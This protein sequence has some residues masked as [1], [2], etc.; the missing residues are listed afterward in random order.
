M[1]CALAVMLFSY[2]RDFVVNR[3]LSVLMVLKMPG[4]AL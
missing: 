3:N 2:K 4:V 1:V